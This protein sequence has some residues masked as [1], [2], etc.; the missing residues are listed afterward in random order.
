MP[1]FAGH[2][3]V[4]ALQVRWTLAQLP[5]SVAASSPTK[6]GALVHSA[7]LPTGVTET[8]FAAEMQSSLRAARTRYQ[9]GRASCRERV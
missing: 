8:V 4:A 2:D 9:N 5:A 3:E 7:A 1:L 6:S